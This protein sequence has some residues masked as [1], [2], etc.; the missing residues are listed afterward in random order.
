MMGHDAVV[1]SNG[2]HW[3][4]TSR[5]IDLNRQP[6]L[7]GTARYV[8]DVVRALPLMRGYDIVHLSNPI[9]LELKPNKVK[10]VFDYLRHH[11]NKIVLSALGTDRVYFDACHDGHTYRY[12]DYMVGNEP[13][14]YV[15]STEYV[16]HEQENWKL[17]IMKSHSDHLLQHVDGIVA[18]LWEYYAAYKPI[19]SDKL[20]YAGI[21]IDTD[22]LRPRPLD[23]EP[24]KVRFFI[25]I[26]QARNILK[27]TDRLLSALQRVHDRFPDLCEMEV[28]ENLPYSEYT[29]RMRQSHVILDQLYSY[30]PATNALIAM[31]Q[32]LVAV[33]GAEPEYYDLIQEH[34]NHP[35]VN[36][37]PYDD[38]D[39]DAQL[40]YIISHKSSLP[41]WSRASRE[42]VEK[43][44]SAAIVAQRHLDF[45]NK[46]LEEP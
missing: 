45:W 23:K 41:E 31:A 33:S 30:T 15:R 8:L 34:D 3:M 37:T 19:V 5:D 21:P 39:I 35:I 4:D 18:C 10:W 7:A 25:G 46:L 6:G 12:S 2:S 14:P 20:A 9:F 36:V 11:N 26:Q 42:F 44:N 13:S 17:P 32:G 43:H 24:Q 40:E 38:W 28:V 22:S 16:E 27:G 29:R 1:A